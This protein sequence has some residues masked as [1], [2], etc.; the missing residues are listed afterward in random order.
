MKKIL[1]Y[2]GLFLTLISL[3]SVLQYVFDYEILSAYGKGYLWGK[4]LLLVLG[5][6]LIYF[7]RRKTSEKQAAE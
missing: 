3:F 6:V 4:L 2:L 7:G 1:F 5:I